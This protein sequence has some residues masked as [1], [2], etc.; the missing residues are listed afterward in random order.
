MGLPFFY[1]EE[2]NIDINKGTATITG[3]QAHHLTRALRV[4]KGNRLI[5]ADGKGTVFSS[6]ITSIGLDEVHLKLETKFFFEKEKPGIVLYQ[7]VL[8]PSTMD[9][10]ISR[11]AESGIEK[12]IPF[13]SE[14]SIV[15]HPGLVVDK[16]QRLRRIAVEASMT[17]RRPWLLQVENPISFNMA[18]EQSTRGFNIV[19][20]E[21]EKTF[22]LSEVLPDTAPSHIN[23]YIGPEGGFGNK[24]IKWFWTKNFKFASLGSL[25]LKALSAGSYAAMLIRYHYG[26]L[27]NPREDYR[28]G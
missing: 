9:E 19:F 20:W 10:V 15:R 8:K 26:L 24:D 5:I 6:I 27:E 1:V 14:R 12:V 18:I 11:A 22:S 2:K 25:N 13:I 4:K 28:I 7:S 17:A 21:E 3:N 16:L 23:I